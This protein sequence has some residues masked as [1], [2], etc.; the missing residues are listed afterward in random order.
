MNSKPRRDKSDEL[1]RQRTDGVAVVRMHCVVGKDSA[2]HAEESEIEHIG[3]VGPSFVL[4]PLNRFVAR[5]RRVKVGVRFG[6]LLLERGRVEL[7][8]E[9][10]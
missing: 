1:Q 7:P 5:Q 2:G 9:K 3:A 8:R 10:G 6:F 4:P